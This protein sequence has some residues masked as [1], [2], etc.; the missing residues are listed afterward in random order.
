M[1]W[2]LYMFVGFCMGFM[3]AIMVGVLL[4]TRDEQRKPKSKDEWRQD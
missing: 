3:A 4:L 1:E 2:L